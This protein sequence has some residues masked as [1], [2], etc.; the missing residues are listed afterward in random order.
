MWNIVSEPFWNAMF[1]F[2]TQQKDVYKLVEQCRADS[3]VQKCIIFG[4]SVTE[5]CHSWS[6][7]DVYFEIKEDIGRLPSVKDA[8]APFD[9]WTNFTVSP[10]L[11]EEID[12]NGVPVF[13]RGPYKL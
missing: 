3:N 11:M 2:P 12:C 9:K 5:E 13:Q 10:E 1:I 8:E 6:D 7:I 4:S